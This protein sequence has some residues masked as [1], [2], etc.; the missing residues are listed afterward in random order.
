MRYTW[1]WSDSGEFIRV[2]TV[3]EESPARNPAFD[4][5]P[6]S[7]ITG[8]ITEKGIIAP[9]EVPTVAPS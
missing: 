9:S 7:L 3:P 4:V 1:G 8:I 2:R 5:T 6:A